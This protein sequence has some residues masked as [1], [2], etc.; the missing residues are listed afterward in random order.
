MARIGGDG[1]EDRGARLEAFPRSP[2]E[3]KGRCVVLKVGCKLGC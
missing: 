3:E 1:L 2:G